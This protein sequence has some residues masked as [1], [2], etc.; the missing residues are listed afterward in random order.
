MIHALA[1]VLAAV[2]LVPAPETGVNS[3]AAQTIK[4]NPVT[5]DL[6]GFRLGMTEAEA[7][8]VLRRRGMT[9]TRRSRGQTFE[10]RVRKLVNLRGG[11]L[12]LAGGSVLATAD[13]DDGM[14]GKIFIRMLAWPD[15]ARIR[16]ITY[17]PP[18]GTDAAAWRSLLVTKYGRPAQD[19]DTIGSEGLHAA[20][21][22]QPSCFGEGRLFR[23]SASVSAKGGQITL[24]QPE[25]T[26]SN[27]TAL[28]EVEASKHRLPGR[29][30]L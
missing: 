9:V 19:V 28:V 2:Q 3:V 13:L 23:L 11:R 5:F 4:G 17:L 26:A 18:A 25:G 7:E 16:G 12:G 21:C 14:G 10:D 1:V 30:A 8:D 20:W 6:A 22:G 15:G 29:P 27:L 24:A